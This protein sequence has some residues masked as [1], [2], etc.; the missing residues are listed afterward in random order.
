[1]ALIACPDCGKSVSDKARACPD[2]GAPIAEAAG[3]SSGRVQEVVLRPAA[4][5]DGRQFGADTATA[6]T[7]PRL[8]LVWFVLIWL[9]TGVV[10]GYR[11]GYLDADPIVW[12]Y[13][14]ATFVAP[15]PVAIVLR[16][17]IRAVVPVVLGS[18]CMLLSI[19]FFVVLFAI[20][21]MFVWNLI[22]R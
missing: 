21:G 10:L 14:L 17:P 19:G 7:N 6:L 11:A 5:V 22:D 20:A 13:V 4:L 12:W 15:I 16:R 18:G 1:M 2:C 8:A 9:V 3:P